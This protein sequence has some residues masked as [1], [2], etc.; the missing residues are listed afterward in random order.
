[1]KNKIILVTGAAGSIGSALSKT[2]AG[3]KPKMLVILDQDETGIF[4]L[5]E[6]IKTKCFTEY[7]IGNIRDKEA[8]DYLFSQF[9]P[10]LIFHCAAYKH[11]VLMEKW[12]NE[13]YKTN[14]LTVYC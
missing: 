13:A 3:L 8:M 9:K 7:A 10:D 4:D 2:I 1:M 11:V 5:Y 12:K 14:I 6:E